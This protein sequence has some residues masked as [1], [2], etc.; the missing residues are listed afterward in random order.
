MRLGLTTFYL[1]FVSFLVDDIAG[2]RR[3]DPLPKYVNP[4]TTGLFRSLKK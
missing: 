4:V 1:Y 2:R 3:A